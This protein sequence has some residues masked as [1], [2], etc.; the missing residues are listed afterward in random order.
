MNGAS[1]PGLPEGLYLRTVGQLEN[2]VLRGY[3]WQ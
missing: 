2:G 3:Y 1:D